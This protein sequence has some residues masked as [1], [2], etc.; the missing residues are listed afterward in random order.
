[1]VNL[2]QRPDC[3]QSHRAW[4]HEIGRV[5]E[6]IEAFA[7]ASIAGRRR[8]GR[9]GKLNRIRRT[10]RRRTGRVL[11]TFLQILLLLALLF[12]SLAGAWLPDPNL[13]R[14]FHFLM[15]GVTGIP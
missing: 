9:F 10:D 4:R 6:R 15:M 13:A 2:F 5:I 14:I 8:D 1:M 7:R 11:V 12:R 3:A